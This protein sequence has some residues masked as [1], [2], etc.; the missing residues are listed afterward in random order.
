[1]GAYHG[2]AS[3]DTFSHAKSVLTRSTRVDPK[4]GYPPY[5]SRKDRIIR[6]FL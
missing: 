4:L 6:R 2:R 3:F 5:T 1:M